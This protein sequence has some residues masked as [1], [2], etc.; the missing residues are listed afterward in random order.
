MKRRVEK[1]VI[2][3]IMTYLLSGCQI[4]L[5]AILL[6]AAIG[7]VRHTQQLVQA[8]RVSSI[9]QFFVS[10]IATIIIILEAELV[11]GLVLGSQRMLPF[12]F[13]GTFL[14]LGA[15]TGWLISVYRRQLNVEC[16]CFGAS[17]AKVGKGSIM[18]N[19]VL[20]GISSLGF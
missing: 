20:M 5:A 18:R 17:R 6:I 19:A 9:S 4:V 8:L 13:G 14:L 2:S 12:I 1:G 3:A 11:L 7:K 10:P 15:F 16:G